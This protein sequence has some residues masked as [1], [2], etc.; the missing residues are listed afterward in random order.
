VRRYPGNNGTAS[1]FAAHL[2]FVPVWIAVHKVFENPRFVSEALIADLG[3]L[4]IHSGFTRLNRADS[5]GRETS[6]PQGGFTCQ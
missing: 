3:E 1:R 5:I 2:R 6:R 4:G